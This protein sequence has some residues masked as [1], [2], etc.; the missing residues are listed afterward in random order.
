[1][2]SVNINIRTDVEVKQKAQRLFEL[3]GMDMTTAV[4]MFLRQAISKNTLPFDILPIADNSV[5]ALGSVKGKITLADGY[6][7]QYEDF[8]EHIR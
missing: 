1:M 7:A 5:P 3:L 6:D 2:T 8:I 4:N